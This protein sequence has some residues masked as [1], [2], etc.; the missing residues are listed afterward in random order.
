MENKEF[1]YKGTTLN[2]FFM[3]FLNLLLNIGAI[4]LLVLAINTMDWPLG[5]GA[6]LL[7]IISV[8]LWPGFMMLEP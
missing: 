1:S 3:L 7:F 4:L 8:F 6:A 2:G 5:V